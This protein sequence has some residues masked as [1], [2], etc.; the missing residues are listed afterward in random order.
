MSLGLTTASG[1]DDT[2]RASLWKGWV[3]SAC[4]SCVFS[5]SL[6]TNVQN[7]GQDCP[8]LLVDHCQICWNLETH[9]KYW[10]NQCGLQL[11]PFTAF[12]VIFDADWTCSTKS[13][14]VKQFWITAGMM[15]AHAMKT[16]CLASK[17]FYFLMSSVGTFKFA[18]YTAHFNY[19]D[20]ICFI[21]C[22]MHITDDV[23][24]QIQPVHVFQGIACSMLLLWQHIVV[25]VNCFPF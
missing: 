7:W 6:P 2:I 19:A 25:L 23:W 20:F 13:A 11:H 22:V 8:D 5:S 9:W 10:G 18:K 16:Y 17:M 14:F 12:I 3:G 4:V 24:Q 21:Q 15:N 1:T